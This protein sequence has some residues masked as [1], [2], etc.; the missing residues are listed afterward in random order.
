MVFT[1]EK[2][3]LFTLMRNR[4]NLAVL[5]AFSCIKQEAVVETE[6][7]RMSEWKRLISTLCCN[8]TEQIV[9][10]ENAKR[11]IMSYVN[12]NAFMKGLCTTFSYVASLS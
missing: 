8:E 2:C 7:I 3:E 5:I 9:R 12:K 6:P 11:G 4:D 10:K 1:G